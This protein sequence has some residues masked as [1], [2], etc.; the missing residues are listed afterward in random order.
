M[1]ILTQDDCDWVYNKDKNA[2]NYPGLQRSIMLK[3]MRKRLFKREG[4]GMTN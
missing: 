2:T 4:Y 3:L 1:F